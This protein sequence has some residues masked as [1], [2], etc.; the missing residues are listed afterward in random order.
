M[1]VLQ[2]VK[3]TTN[4]TLSDNDKVVMDNVWK[5]MTDYWNVQKP[6]LIISVTGG[7]KNFLMNNRLRNNVKRGLI[8]ASTSAGSTVLNYKSF[9]SH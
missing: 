2:Y 9:T 1:I 8:K 4:E 5:L 6:K 3:V 7:A